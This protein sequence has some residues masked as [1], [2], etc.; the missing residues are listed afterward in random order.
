MWLPQSQFVWLWV[1]EIPLSQATR[2]PSVGPSYLKRLWLE[3]VLIFQWNNEH[4][5]KGY[6]YIHIWKIKC[7]FSGRNKGKHGGVPI[8]KI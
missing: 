7:V 8:K 3:D 2:R 1:T 6:D 5:V 4:L